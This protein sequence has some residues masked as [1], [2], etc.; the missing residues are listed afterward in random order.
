MPIYSKI[1]M[2]LDI[3]DVKHELIEDPSTHSCKALK[4]AWLANN[5]RI[6]DHVD[7]LVRYIGNKRV[8]MT[9][10]TE[11]DTEVAEALKEKI[12][13]EGYEV[14]ELSYSSFMV[15]AGLKTPVGHTLTTYR[16]RKLLCSDATCK[17][18]QGRLCSKLRLVSHT[19]Q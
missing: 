18:R 16:H 9:N 19:W 8:L 12:E 11:Y 3:Y 10:C 2:V 15:H 4:P 17:G 5:A 7:C 13:A 1:V 6:T 14:V